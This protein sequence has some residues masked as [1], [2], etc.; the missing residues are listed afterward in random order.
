MEHAALHAGDAP[1]TITGCRIRRGHFGVFVVGAD[2][3]FKA[4]DPCGRV[5]VVGNRIDNCKKGV[6]VGGW[7]YEV[8]VVGNVIW[9]GGTWGALEIMVLAPGARDIVIA[10]NTL[11]ETEYAL[12]LWDRDV[13]GSRVEI[14]NNL[15]LATTSSADMVYV[16]CG[17]DIWNEWRFGDGV[18]PAER[19]RM[20][21]NWR[22]T[23]R[24]TDDESSRW[25]IRPGASG[26]I[27]ATID[28]TS[29][30]P[31]SPDFLKPP[32]DSPLGDSGADVDH[33]PGRRES[34]MDCPIPAKPNAR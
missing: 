24:P 26:G 12:R 32:T 11:F 8:H 31:A 19:W 28:V 14:R 1:I 30:D 34:W 2:K 27:H 20:S 7:C 18:V 9:G 23:T 25:W 29:R 10:N 13:N 22:E 5:R 16:Q 15:V 3:N 17:D 4:F 33:L 21:H 6:A